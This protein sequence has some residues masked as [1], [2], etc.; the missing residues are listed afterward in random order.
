MESDPSQNEQLEGALQKDEREGFMHIVTTIA[1]PGQ[2]LQSV[3]RSTLDENLKRAARSVFPFI[4]EM[5]YTK[6]TTDEWTEG[7]SSDLTPEAEILWW[8][9]LSLTSII[10]SFTAIN[11][12]FDSFRYDMADRNI[13]AHPFG[14]LENEDL[15][16]SFLAISRKIRSEHSDFLFMHMNGQESEGRFPVV[17]RER[18]LCA[19]QEV[20]DASKTRGQEVIMLKKR[21]Y[22]Q[23]F[24]CCD[25]CG[26]KERVLLKC[27]KCT[28]GTYCGKEC[29]KQ[30]WPKHR[31]SC[32]KA[33][34]G[35][36]SAAKDNNSK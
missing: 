13:I 22:A 28:K 15:R 25:V 6:C 31:S 14:V 18:C 1:R 33:S 8:Q 27:M 24:L 35:S 9:R 23:L 7:F 16:G 4:K 20:M 29:Q 21:R 19:L 34:A 3:R 10:A 2:V 26:K 36:S 30:D 17:V 32:K 5:G 11:K 12:S